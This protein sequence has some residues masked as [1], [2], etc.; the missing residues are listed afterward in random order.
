MRAI[1]TST[2]SLHDVAGA[3]ANFAGAKCLEPV[4]GWRHGT[5]VAFL[6]TGSSCLGLHEAAEHQVSHKPGAARRQ[7]DERLIVRCGIAHAHLLGR[8]KL[9]RPIRGGIDP[10]DRVAAQ[11]AFALAVVL[12]QPEED[13]VSSKR[14]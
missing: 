9:P 2:A 7:G 11:E 5:V 4:I 14:R 13:L 12:N 3:T 1:A 6:S 10:L 8:V